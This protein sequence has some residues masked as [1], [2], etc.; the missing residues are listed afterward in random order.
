M[1]ITAHKL[2]REDDT[3]TFILCD[4]KKG[5]VIVKD[6]DGTNGTKQLHMTGKR[7]EN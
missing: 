6:F 4:L 1:L 7:V 3:P 5:T 2:D